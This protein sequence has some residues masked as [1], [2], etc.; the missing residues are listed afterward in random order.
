MSRA[1][2]GL[3]KVL[4]SLWKESP[5]AK[6]QVE[7]DGQESQ[8]RGHVLLVSEEMFTLGEQVCVDVSG[9]VCTHRV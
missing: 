9:C 4:V 1:C 2:T 5:K 6:V 7:P 8:C 3:L